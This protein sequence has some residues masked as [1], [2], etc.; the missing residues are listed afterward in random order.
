MIND[1]VL[2]VLMNKYGDMVLRTCFL[3]LRDYHLAE[4][5][6]QET[7]VKVFKSYEK[8]EHR[9]DEKT[10]IIKIAINCCKNIRRTHW[11]SVKKC[12]YDELSEKIEEKNSSL[13]EKENKQILSNAI[14]QLNDKDREII[15][16]YYYPEFSIEEIALVMDKKENSMCQQLRRARNKLKKILLQEGYQN[17][18]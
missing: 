16:L 2:E 18:I 17:E 14:M 7:F 9:S 1:Q 4:D 12:S 15:I 10:W 5:A 6:T 8:F 3:Y 13:P 11:F